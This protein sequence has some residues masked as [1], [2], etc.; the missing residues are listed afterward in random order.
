M[1][2][3]HS[4]R[5]MQY[6]L[7]KWRLFAMESFPTLEGNLENSNNEDRRGRSNIASGGGG[8]GRH[9]VTLRTDRG[10]SINNVTVLRNK[11]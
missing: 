7:N 1:R 8:G 2:G 3:S 9:F 10:S 6:R 4:Y 11:G 5:L